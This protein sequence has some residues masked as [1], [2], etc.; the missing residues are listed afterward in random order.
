MKAL[1]PTRV[2]E[3]IFGLL[4]AMFAVG[5]FTSTADMAASIPSYFPGGGEIWV[6]LA[7]AGLG[8]AA[9]AIIL[10]I[11]KTLACYLLAAE[12][13]IFVFT[14]HLQ[15]AMDGDMGLLLRDAAMAMAAI[16][17]GNNAAKR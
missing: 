5:H 17:I 8:A 12:I 10:N 13:L 2:A 16:L 4:I 11:Q 1:I 6:Y 15:P 3:V 14:L 9:L 7:G